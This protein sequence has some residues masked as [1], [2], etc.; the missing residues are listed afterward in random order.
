MA[1]SMLPGVG[2]VCVCQDQVVNILDI[3]RLAIKISNVKKLEG[4]IRCHFNSTILFRTFP[5]LFPRLWDILS[6]V[7]LIFL[8]TSMKHNVFSGPLQRQHHPHCR[9]SN[10]RSSSYLC[11]CADLCLETVLIIT[12]LSVISTHN[13][14]ILSFQKSLSI[15][16]TAFFGPWPWP[17]HRNPPSQTSK[18]AGLP[19]ICISI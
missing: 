9:L 8:S 7:P 5:K 16:F 1:C 14:Y 17:W 3:R 15:L 11:I 10:A 2:D 18:L 4:R 19:T 13:E 12:S 6:H